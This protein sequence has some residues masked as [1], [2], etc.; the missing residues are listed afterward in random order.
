M[1]RFA[2][3]AIATLIFSASFASADFRVKKAVLSY[4]APVLFALPSSLDVH[5]RFDILINQIVLDPVFTNNFNR[6]VVFP[7]TGS[8]ALKEGF[9][10]VAR[11]PPKSFL[12]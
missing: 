6:L 2:I 5:P 3:I 1:K 11:G 12:K 10:S 9:N 4:H 7:E 8:S